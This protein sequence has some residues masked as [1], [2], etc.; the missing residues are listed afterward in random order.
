MFEHLVS[1]SNELQLFFRILKWFHLI[2]N[3]SQIHIDGLWH[4]KDTCPTHRC[5]TKKSMFWSLLPPH[6]VWALSFSAPVHINMCVYVWG[7]IPLYRANCECPSLF[8]HAPRY[9]W[10]FSSICFSWNTFIVLSVLTLQKYITCGSIMSGQRSE[11]DRMVAFSVDILSLG[12][13]SLFQT[14]IWVSSVSRDRGSSPSVIGIG[15]WN[16][17]ILKLSFVSSLH[18]WQQ[19]EG[20]DKVVPLLN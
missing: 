7:C 12:R 13:P 20:K 19:L 14:A 8:L 1:I 5:L 15:D 2:S 3:L 6:E 11:L 10:I 16:N 17:Y 18:L 4:C 9:L